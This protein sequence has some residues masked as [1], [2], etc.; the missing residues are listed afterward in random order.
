MRTLKTNPFVD[1]IILILLFILASLCLYHGFRPIILIFTHEA[2]LSMV[3]KTLPLIIANG[4]PFTF[5][6]SHWRRMHVKNISTKYKLYR[7]FSI[8]V[9]IQSALGFITQLVSC[10]T[11]IGWGLF[12]GVSGLYPYDLFV[13]T[14]VL[15][16]YSILCL[17]SLNKN[18]DLK[19]VPLTFKGEK[20]STLV[21]FTLVLGFSCYEFGNVIYN[22]ISAFGDGMFDPNIGLMVPT[23]LLFLT[24][25]FYLVIYL[26]YK[27]IF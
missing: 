19:G 8:A 20:K 22:S 6:L 18:K 11:Q 26:L 15:I 12:K 4:I 21:L 23:I 13:I 16:I 17:V 9:L 3:L 14:F 25:S 27:K 7:S 10:A 1:K 2:R 5:L 24:P